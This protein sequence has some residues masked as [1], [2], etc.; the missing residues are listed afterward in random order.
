[1]PV[2]AVPTASL[3]VIEA[4]FLF[5]IFVKLLD[6]PASVGKPDQSFQG[7]LWWQG[8]EAIFRLLWLLARLFSSRCLLLARLCS[9]HR[10]LSQQPARGSGLHPTVAG[11]VPG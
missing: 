5:G 3:E 8:A 9:G 2:Q 6:D 4:A 10:T 11:R 1:M 7:G